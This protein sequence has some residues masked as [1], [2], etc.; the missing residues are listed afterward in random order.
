MLYANASKDCFFDIPAGTELP[1]GPFELQNLR[2]EQ[3]SVLE[4]AVAPFEIPVEQ[5]KA[6]AAREMRQVKESLAEL[7]KHADAIKQAVREG[8]EGLKEAV[9]G[10]LES[11]KA[12][13]LSGLEQTVTQALAPA[14]MAL[15]QAL[16]EETAATPEGRAWLSEMAERV[17]AGG[18][19]DWTD[20]PAAIPQKL[21]ETLGDPAL[22]DKVESLR[23]A[24]RDQL[25]SRLDARDAR[26]KAED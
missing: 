3:R 18:G 4:S 5:A 10:N 19:P 15:R 12:L 25:K 22:V 24:L 6:Q 26:K 13:D 20:D 11:T 23:G 8:G 21:R 17:K 1:D 9:K 14:G 7:R 16:D 2:R